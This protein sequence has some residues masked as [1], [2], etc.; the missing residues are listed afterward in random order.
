MAT[1]EL[2]KFK[3]MIPLLLKSKDIWTHYDEA[4]DVLYVH[5]EKPNEAADSELLDNDTLVRYDVDGK[6]IGVTFMHA[7]KV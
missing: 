7:S 5:F 3:G 2:E 1:I 4:A 6:I